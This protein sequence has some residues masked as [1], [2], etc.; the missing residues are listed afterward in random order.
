VSKSI[1]TASGAQP[2]IGFGATTFSVLGGSFTNTGTEARTNPKFRSAGTLTNLAVAVPANTLVGGTTTIGIRKNLVLQSL[3]VSVPVGTTGVFE[4]TTNSVTVA[5]GDNIGL[6]LVNSGNASGS[7]TYG[8]TAV[9]FD[10]TT[11]TVSKLVSGAAP[12]T[13][14]ANATT[15][16]C[17]CTGALS[18]NA[19]EALVQFKAQ[20]GGTLR[21]LYFRVQSNSRTT[22]TTVKSRVNGADGNQAVSI[23][24]GTTG[25]FEDTSNSDTVSAGDLL[26][27]SILGGAEATSLTCSPASLEFQNTSGYFL[28]GGTLGVAQGAGTNRYSSL[29]QGPNSANVEPGQK[30]RIKEAVTFSKLS[31]Y[32]SASTTAGAAAAVIRKNGADG[33]QSVTIPAATTGWFTDATNSDTFA[34]GDDFS[35]ATRNPGSGTLTSQTMSYI[36]LIGASGIAA[37]LAQTIANFSLSGTATVLVSAALSRTLPNFTLSSGAAALIQAAGVSSFGNITSAAAATVNIAASGV[38]NFSNFTSSSGATVS[39]T[40]AA[41][42]TIPNFS[43]AAAVNTG[44]VEITATVAVTFPPFLAGATASRFPLLVDARGTPIFPT[45]PSRPRF[46]DVIVKYHYQDGRRP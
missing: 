28:S 43:L 46:G 15:N 27:M 36:G 23:S 16:Y 13:F 44:G 38:A 19:T 26:C 33:S 25:E 17:P 4:D 21:N 29:G 40:A 2:S 12:A 11:N 45:E 9:T 8:N 35:I 34:A 37:D 7:I 18:F 6:T 10:A 39:V 41:T 32:V 31:I 24:A 20:I 5:A 30:T 3:A 22:T 14:N 42:V 1:L